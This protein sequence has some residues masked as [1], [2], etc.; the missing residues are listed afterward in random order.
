MRLPRHS[1]AITH[2]KRDA[3]LAWLETGREGQG[4]LRTQHAL[5]VRDALHAT[6]LR[7][8][9]FEDTRLEA[10][11]LVSA[12]LQQSVFTSCEL[13]TVNLESARLQETTWSGCAF[14]QGRLTLTKGDDLVMRHC[15]LEGALIDRA[16]W[17]GARLEAVSLH[18]AVLT[19][20]DLTDATLEDCDLRDADLTDAELKGAVFRR[21]DL[22]GARLPGNGPELEDCRLDD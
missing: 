15:R 16:R 7:A 6:D 21:C 10:V 22:R 12:R 19:G 17:P 8:A 3:H 9:L 5:L 13:D 18:E 14:F 11:I 20:I 2:R 4:R 1:S